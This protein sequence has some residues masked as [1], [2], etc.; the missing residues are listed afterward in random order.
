MLSTHEIEE[1][2][3]DD[4]VAK[5]KT[6]KR[7]SSAVR[8]ALEVAYLILQ[9][10]I[11]S[12]PKDMMGIL[13]F[14]TEET[15]FP[16][17]AIYE[18]CYLLMDLDIPDAESI[19]RLKNILEDEKEFNKIMKPSKKKAAMN[20]VLFGATQIFTTKAPNFNSRRLFIVTDDDDP[21]SSDQTVKKSAVT[22]ARDCYDLGIRIEPFYIS[23]PNRKQ[24][25]PGLFYEDIIYRSADADD[26]DAPLHL[27]PTNDGKLRLREMVEGIRS[28]TSPK[29]ALFTSRLELGPG[30]KIGV[31]GFLL[32]K[33]QEP[34]RACYVY[35]KGE[36][37]QVAVLETE[38]IAED[39]A[40]KVAKQDVLKAYK[41][42]GEQ[43]YFTPEELASMR[44]FD[45][46]I[47][48]IIG[49]K[50]RA[51][52]K[53]EH[54]VRTSSFI[55]PDEAEIVGSTRVF[56]A[57]H[58]T[59]LKSDKIGIAWHVPRKNS[60]PVLVAL[61]PTPEIL[62]DDTQLAPS[63]I[64]CI[65]LPFADDLRQNP[66][67]ETKEAPNVLK[68]AMRAVVKQLHIPRGYIPDKY[69]NPA[70]QWHYR[71]LQAIALDEDVPSREEREDQT[72]PKYK[73]GLIPSSA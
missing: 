68:T 60:S 46:P 32:F 62:M 28:K 65:Q 14:G 42:G 59:L 50:P 43:V 61:Y 11:I 67:V 49:F 51:A 1:D 17:G 30:V 73:V 33:R 24:F 64:F 26:D 22:R 13:L 66:P 58:K 54:Q 63:G 52:L 16:E 36:K 23:N 37:A 47:I 5:K 20:N 44:H 29:R 34:S 71:C 8:T 6:K 45:D 41:F 19:K 25:D 38:R 39:T 7:P 53:F 40:R 48:R 15:K 18:H 4:P 2:D 55:Y 12:D 9:Q 56:A 69:A 21:H 35:T 10:R 72:V 31:K 27:K 3:G 57:L 70:L